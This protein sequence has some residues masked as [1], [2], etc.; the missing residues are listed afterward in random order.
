MADFKLIITLIL[1]L[2]CYALGNTCNRLF[3][4]QTFVDRAE[5]YYPK[6]IQHPSFRR[7]MNMLIVSDPQSRNSRFS[8][9]PNLVRLSEQVID[10]AKAPISGTQKNKALANI[11]DLYSVFDIFQN[12][13]FVDYEAKLFLKSLLTH[14]ASVN[15][16]YNI[17]TQ[18]NINSGFRLAA[19]DVLKRSESELIEIKQLDPQSDLFKN[20]VQI[21][22]RKLPALIDQQILDKKFEWRQAQEA[23]LERQREIEAAEKRQKKIKSEIEKKYKK[24]YERKNL[25]PAFRR[26]IDIYFESL[27]NPRFAEILEKLTR[28]E[29]FMKQAPDKQNIIFYILNGMVVKAYASTNETH[30]ALLTHTINFIVNGYFPV[31]FN[32]INGAGGFAHL[33]YIEINSDGFRRIDGTFDP[34][35]VAKAADYLAH[36]VSHTISRQRVEESYNYFVEEYRASQV[37]FFAANGKFMTDREALSMAFDLITNSYHLPAYDYIRRDFLKHFNSPDY[38]NFFKLFDLSSADIFNRLYNGPISQRTLEGFIKAASNTRTA[39]QIGWPGFI[40]NSP[41]PDSTDRYLQRE[42]IN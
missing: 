12:T 29:W 13:Y 37:G 35:L 39:P 26:Q 8:G 23:A 11:A 10:L 31:I 38:K 42:I 40:T 21:F 27:Y 3:Q 14:P 15:L 28:Y 20:A 18:A 34:V 33:Q 30:Q 9:E 7:I 2:Q 16:L 19:I 4:P 1:F 22:L 25:D 24:V 17:G 6:I 5:E 32:E 36:E 41:K